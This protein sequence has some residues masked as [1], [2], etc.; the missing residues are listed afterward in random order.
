MV[1]NKYLFN[2]FK[3]TSLESQV[4]ENITENAE[5]KQENSAAEE[6]VIETTQQQRSVEEEKINQENTLQ[7]EQ[8]KPII[9]KLKTKKQKRKKE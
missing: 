2:H 7:K 9:P 8:E 3:K 4:I 5:N 1:G 6:V